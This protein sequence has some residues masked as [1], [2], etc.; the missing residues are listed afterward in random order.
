MEG[1]AQALPKSRIS[2]QINKDFNHKQLPST[3]RI[4]TTKND[5]DDSF[6][7]RNSTKSDI[8]SESRIT[9]EKSRN[10]DRIIINI[11]DSIQFRQDNV[12][13]FVTNEG[14]PCDIGAKKLIEF[15][16]VKADQKYNIGEV[17]KIKKNKK[18]YQFALCIR[19]QTPESLTDIK[20]SIYN[21]LIVLRE[22]LISSKQIEISFAKSDTIENLDWSEILNLFDLVFRE[23]NIKVLVCTGKLKYV[24]IEK[25]DEVFYELHKS[26]VGGHRGVSKTY[27]R[28]RNEYYWEHLKDDIQR[29]VQQ[30]LDC[31]LKKL[32]RLKTK[33]P[34]VIT[35]TPGVTFDKIAMD[36]VGP[37]KPTKMGNEYILTLQDQLSKFCLAVP[38]S[39][40]LASTIADAFIKKFVC[41]FGA[42]K[43]IL[44]DQGQNFLSSLM[45]R[46]AKRFKIKKLRTTAFRPQSN[47]SLERSHHALAEYLK[48]YT[49]TDHEWDEWL[50]L[51]MLNYN[52]CTQ[53]STKHTPFEVVFGRIARLPSSDPLREGDMLPTYK[54]YIIDLVTRLN[55][56]QKLAYNNLVSSKFRSKKYYDRKINP[57]N[58]K[59]GDFVFLQSGPKPNKFGDHYSGPY[60]I[61]QVLNR[62]NIK[63]EIKGKNKIVHANRLR[64]SHINH[65]VKVKNKTKTKLIDE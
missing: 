51:A 50:D 2:T 7:E 56:I 11:K 18:Y 39:N 45:T 32:V 36:I 26:P 21:T 47:G 41:V 37:L 5:I 49:D 23:T 25:R 33:Q 54:G 63:L 31:Q 28:I 46:I 3:S 16:Q 29:R 19:G 34:M 58:F 13:Y 24:P 10:S 6:L 20:E 38:L 14:R 57:T 15:D 48:Q 64:I 27:N 12:A 59:V 1:Q 9:M 30:C 53:E 17:S 43:V 35:D 8:I 42:P 40:T 61:L 55:S 4:L 65:P 60:K 44:T 22:L 52:T 62:N